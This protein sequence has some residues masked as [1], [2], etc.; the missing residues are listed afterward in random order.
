MYKYLSRVG[1]AGTK[2]LFTFRSWTHR[3]NEELS[4]HG[5][6]EGKSECTYCTLD[7]VRVLGVSFSSTCSRA[8]FVE[9]FWYDRSCV[10]LAQGHIG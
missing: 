9:G 1:S 4:R 5:G 8:T 6:R 2:H 3:L 7:I 10:H